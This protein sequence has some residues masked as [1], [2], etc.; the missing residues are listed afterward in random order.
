MNHHTRRSFLQTSTLA[1]SAAALSPTLVA[2]AEGPA[3]RRAFKKAIMWETVGFKGTILEKCK[4][5]K[6]AGFEGIE[7]S[8]HMNQDEVVKAME[9][10]GLQAA[11]VCCSTHWSKPA[12]DPSPAVREAS[13][14]GLK[15]ALRDAK[16]YGATS[17]LFVP[18]VV[19]KQVSYADAYTRSQAVIREAVPLAEELGVR[20]ALENVWNSFHLS[21]LEA[22]RY[23][24]EFKSPWVG[25]HFDCGNVCNYGFPEQWIR[26]LGQRISR[27]HIKEFS[28]QKADK[29]GKW[30]G[31]ECKLLEGDNDWPAIMQALDDVGYSGWAI[32]EQGGADSLDGMKDLVAR[33]GKILAS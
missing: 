24:D 31:F 4:A 12:S 19:N 18:G 25:W 32:S 13:L 5:I 23:V 26:I 16:R 20:I 10:T 11:S 29:E 8:S 17:V 22:A 3:T 27:I 14:A 2:A 15:Q 9:V 21:P 33:M 30:K 6:E 7:P 28:R 1:L